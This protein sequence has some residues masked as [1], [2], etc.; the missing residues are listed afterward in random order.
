MRRGNRAERSFPLPAALLGLFVAGVGLILA[1]ILVASAGN[2]GGIPPEPLAY[3][4]PPVYN[5]PGLP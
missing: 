3:N 1:T 4:P 5:P 2:G